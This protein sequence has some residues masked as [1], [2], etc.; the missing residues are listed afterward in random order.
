MPEHLKNMAL[1]VNCH[2]MEHSREKYTCKPKKVICYSVHQMRRGGG[3][4][5]SANAPG[6]VFENFNRAIWEAL[7]TGSVAIHCLAGVFIYHDSCFDVFLL[8]NPSVINLTNISDVI[9]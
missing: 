3:K 7:Q 5:D 6:R 4:I 1:I 9:F 2:Q 8:L